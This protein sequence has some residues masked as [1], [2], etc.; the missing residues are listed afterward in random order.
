MGHLR[1]PHDLASY[2]VG[3]LGVPSKDMEVRGGCAV[4][5]YIEQVV[6]DLD[7]G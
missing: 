2:A 6:V 5:L 1:Q 4:C 7:G 3:A